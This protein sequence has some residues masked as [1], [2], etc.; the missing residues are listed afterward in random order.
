MIMKTR[1]FNSLP[2]SRGLI[3][4]SNSTLRVMYE[5]LQSERFL[6]PQHSSHTPQSDQNTLY[7][8]LRY[9]V[10]ETGQNVVQ[11][12]CVVDL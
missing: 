11:K 7:V 4:L 8:L 12:S 1:G 3:Q 2:S 5:V 10:Q 6:L 9:R